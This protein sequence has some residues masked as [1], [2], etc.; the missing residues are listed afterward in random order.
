MFNL[1]CEK[2]R[3]PLSEQDYNTKLKES[4]HWDIQSNF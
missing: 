4:F 3:S 1:E 2:Q